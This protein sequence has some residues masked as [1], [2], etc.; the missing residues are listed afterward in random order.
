MRSLIWSLIERVFPRLASALLMVLLAQYV[1][2]VVIGLY[3]WPMLV[4]TFYYSALDGAIRQVV[5]PSLANRDSYQFLLRYRRWASVGGVVAMLVTIGLLWIIFPEDLHTQIFALLPLVA[6]PIANSYSIIP[7]GFL[8]RGDEWRRLANLQLLVSGLSLVVSVPML[9]LTRSLAAASLQVLLAELLFAV[10]AHRAAARLGLP[11]HVEALGAGTTLTREFRHSSGFFILGWLQGQADR[12]LLGAIAGTAALGS[13]NLAMAVARN[14]GDAV[15]SSTAN[16][17]RVRLDKADGVD[18]VRGAA[19][20]L[21]VRAALLSAALVVVLN[22]G[23][24]FILRPFL[25][26]AWTKPLDAVYPAS[27]SILVTTITWSLAPVLMARGRL[28]WGTPIKAVGVVLA[29]PIAVA[30]AHSVESAAWVYLGRELVL[31]VLLAFGCGRATP[32]RA[33]GLSLLLTVAL[34]VALG[35]LSQLG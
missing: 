26:A 23:T 27:L 7:L 33:V 13:Y 15:S 24:E 9:F 5:V 11:A 1:T 3:A 16:V 8:Q 31:L 29:I 35:A 4:L 18:D 14:P 20:A 34:G 12:I 22:V 25:G 17:L 30:A 6:V 21:L 2:P 10:L 19:N 32:Y 28:A